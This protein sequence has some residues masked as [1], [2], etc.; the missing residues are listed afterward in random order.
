MLSPHILSVV[1][2]SVYKIHQQTK[3][4]ISKSIENEKNLSEYNSSKYNKLE[5]KKLQH[6][7]K[8]FLRCIRLQ[9]K[10]PSRQSVRQSNGQ[11]RGKTEAKK[12]LKDKKNRQGEFLL[13][14]LIEDAM[15]RHLQIL[16]AYHLN[17]ITIKWYK[18][19]SC[20]PGVVYFR[21]G[22][23]LLSHKT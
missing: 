12:Q 17:I 5:T 23:G 1:V 2:I 22:S 15:Q 4:R 10:K 13:Q 20:V 18:V 14:Q 16:Q 21:N 6:I 9:K 11:T 3:Q 19:K 7:R 8:F